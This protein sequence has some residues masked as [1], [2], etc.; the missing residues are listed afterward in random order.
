M[1]QIFTIDDMVSSYGVYQEQH[2]TYKRYDEMSMR[3]RVKE[4]ER[5][6]KKNGDPERTVQQLVKDAKCRAKKKGIPFNITNEFIFYLIE[7]N[8]MRCAKTGAL[9][10]F[11]KNNPNK[12]SIDRIDS[13][14]GYTVDNVQLVTVAVN[15]AKG[16]MTEKEF[17]TM[18]M[19]VVKK[20][21]FKTNSKK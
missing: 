15:K 19:D 6:E 13:S 3:K 2:P 1:T 9:M 10:T 18:C 14:G 16:P 7:E 12:L 4:R 20:N 21:L 17:D 5:Y 8:A 11:F